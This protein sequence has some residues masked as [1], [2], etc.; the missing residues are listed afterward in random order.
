MPQLQPLADHVI[1]R[2][3]RETQTAS[4]LVIPDTIKDAKTD[5][6]EVIAVGPGRML[7]DGSRSPMNVKEN[8]QVVFSKYAADEIQIEGEDFLVLSETDIKAIIQ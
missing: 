6:G 2:S 3:H 1:V 4:G 7:E 8:D 5:R